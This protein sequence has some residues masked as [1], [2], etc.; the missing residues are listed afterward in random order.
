MIVCALQLPGEDFDTIVAGKTL[1]PRRT[2]ATREAIQKILDIRIAEYPTTVAEDEA[3][4]TDPQLSLRRR[5]AIFVRM[6]EKR[7]LLNAKDEL[8]KWDIREAT[9]HPPPKRPRTQ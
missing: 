8:A 7:L 4:L 1:K 9:D 5:N 2:A 3:K 6:G